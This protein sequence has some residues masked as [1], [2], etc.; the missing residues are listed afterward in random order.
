MLTTHNFHCCLL[1]VAKDLTVERMRRFVFL[2]FIFFLS[3]FQVVNAVKPCYLLSL[4]QMIGMALKSH[5]RFYASLPLN[6]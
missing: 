3:Y 6:S 1:A 5:P 2:P 4:G